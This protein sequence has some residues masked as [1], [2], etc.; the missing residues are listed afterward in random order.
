[1][2]ADNYRDE[3]SRKTLARHFMVYKEV[4]LFMAFAFILKRD[5]E[6]HNTVRERLKRLLSQG[7][8]SEVRKK[9]DENVYRI[10]RKFYDEYKQT[11]ELGHALKSAFCWTVPENGAVTAERLS[12]LCDKDEMQRIFIYTYDA[13]LREYRKCPK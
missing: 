10:S 5:K 2:L 4:S 13:L 9:W 11:K 7:L 8:L 6:L 3:Q 1:M 12:E